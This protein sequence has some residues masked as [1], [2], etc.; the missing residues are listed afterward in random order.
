MVCNGSAG[1]RTRSVLW[2]AI[3]CFIE[4]VRTLV[5]HGGRWWNLRGA[6]GRLALKLQAG[7]TAAAG[8][9]NV[10][11]SSDGGPEQT[12]KGEERDH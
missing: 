10:A 3:R 1:I 9:T 6:W 11:R 2:P 8:S 7:A 5:L 4:F 12:R